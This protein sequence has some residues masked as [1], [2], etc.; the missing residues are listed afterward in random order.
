MVSY[1][2]CGDSHNFG[3]RVLVLQDGIGNLRVEKPRTVFW[4]YLFL[5]SRSPFRQIIRELSTQINFDSMLGNIH[6][7]MS[8]DMCSGVASFY[9]EPNY[10]LFKPSAS[11]FLNFGRTLAFCSIF[12]I[13]DLHKDNAL[14]SEC[15]IQ[16][17]DIES[18]FW[19][20]LI[21][22]ETL[23]LPKTTE[24]I[25]RNILSKV[26][27]TELRSF[28]DEKVSNV[29]V[30][31]IEVFSFFLNLN[32][33]S[34]FLNKIQFLNSQIEGFPVRVLLRDTRDYLKKNN[35]YSEEVDQLS[36]GDIPYFFFI[37]GGS[38]ELLYYSDFNCVSRLISNNDSISKKVKKSVNS[39]T[40]LLSGE[41]LIQLE[42]NLISEVLD[43]LW[44]RNSTF[45]KYEELKVKRDAGSI[46][47]STGHSVFKFK[48]RN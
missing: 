12:G 31:A 39:I 41:R 40:S 35:F 25:H 37:Y 5:D 45:M 21:P 10:D 16:I 33:N 27:L 47:V 15:G 22:S 11:W 3:R 14:V 34:E 46:F 7:E 48:D 26:G 43:K 19:N 1:V 18:V 30:G 38:K 4:E 36:R 6:I 23:L 20:T 8:N 9:S 42:K 2:K 17:V 28:S 29:V 13:T 32:K 44:S 24:D